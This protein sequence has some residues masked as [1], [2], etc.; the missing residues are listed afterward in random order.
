[1][2]YTLNLYSAVCQLYLNKTEEKI[3]NKYFF[4]KTPMD[5]KLGAG[6][7]MEPTEVKF[8]KQPNRETSG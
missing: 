6:S 4:G 7:C 3:I 2:L 5:S 8:H 1:M